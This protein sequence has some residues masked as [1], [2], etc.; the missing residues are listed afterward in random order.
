[1][2]VFIKIREGIW[3]QIGNDIDGDAF[4]DLFGTSVSLSSDGSIVAIGARLND[5]G[6]FDSG[7]V[8]IYENQNGTWIQLGE[9]IQGE[10]VADGFGESLSLSS[11]GNI[12]AIGAGSN[13]GNGNLSGH[14]RIYENQNGIWIQLGSDIDGESE[15][16]FSGNAV[17]LSFNGSIVAIGASAN[18]GNGENSGHVRVYDLSA[19]Y[20]QKNF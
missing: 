16:D 15:F 4:D 7:H 14:V 10:A 6:G 8:R 3:T 18:D 17:S 11:N 20:L 9:D 12:V 1:M 5:G 2:C 13:D 19:F